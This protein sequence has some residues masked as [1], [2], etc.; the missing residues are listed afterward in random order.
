M[1]YENDLHKKIVYK[2]S[3]IVNRKWFSCFIL[4]DTMIDANNQMLLATYT[5]YLAYLLQLCIYCFEFW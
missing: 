5:C 4:E 1:Y 2:L 3:Q